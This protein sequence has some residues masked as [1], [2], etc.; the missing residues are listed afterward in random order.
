VIEQETLPWEIGMVNL[1]E[2]LDPL[3]V[4]RRLTGHGMQDVYNKII[5][6]QWTL[7]APPL[8]RV[9][10]AAIRFYHT[11]QVN[12]LEEHWRSDLPDLVVSLI[13]HFNRAI[14]QSLRR[15]SQSIPF[16]TVMTDIA[17]YPPHFWIEPQEQYLICGSSRAVEQALALGFPERLI[18]RT[19]GM[20]IHPRFYSSVIVDRALELQMLGLDPSFPTGLVMFGGLGSQAMLEIADRLEEMSS[21]LQ[22]ILICGHNDTLAEALRRQQGRLR[23]HIVGFTTD[24]PHY[25]RL[26]DFFIGKP[27]P[28]SISEA[29]AM[30][31]PVIVERNASTLPQERYN[32][33]W[34]EEMQVG[35]VVRS[36]RFIAAAL[37]RIL[38]PEVLSLFRTHAAALNNRAVFEIPSI[39][40]QILQGTTRRRLATA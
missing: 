26:C 38:R 12:L 3:D 9:L 5:K 29:L 40:L 33:Q 31:L 30:H 36:F 35:M 8:N 39:L 19:S 13:P 10:H 1:Q 32:T 16:V 20:I 14:L 4:V 27:G 25:M 24:V 7:A 2:V 6:R 34:V 15:L 18:F 37:E 28:G 11:R 21:R 17:D 23:K 22:L